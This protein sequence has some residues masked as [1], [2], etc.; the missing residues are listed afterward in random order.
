MLEKLSRCTRL[1]FGG[2]LK[3]L[4]LTWLNAKVGQLL[5]LG[6]SPVS[7]EVPEKIV[8]FYLFNY[9]CRPLPWL[10][11]YSAAKAATHS[12]MDSLWME[13]KPLGINVSLVAGGFVHSNLAKN[14]LHLL[15]LPE[16]SLYSSMGDTIYNTVRVGSSSWATIM[17]T[18]EF[19]GRVANETVKKNPPRYMCIGGQTFWFKLLSWFPR[20]F[21]LMLLWKRA[22]N[23]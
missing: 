17:E 9:A 18:K 1:L 8:M 5:L 10:G 11:T 13:C 15:R 21:G 23:M 16:N 19:A 4:L 7:C 12:I 14:G 20:V 6:L 3:L 2:F 22:M